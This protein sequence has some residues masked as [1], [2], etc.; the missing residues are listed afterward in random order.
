VSR[1]ENN[2]IIQQ[3]HHLGWP[4][5]RTWPSAWSRILP[6]IETAMLPIDWV[7]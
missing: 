3:H 7:S 4:H 2:I 5:P 1:I 6:H